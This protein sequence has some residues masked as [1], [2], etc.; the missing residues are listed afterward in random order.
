MKKLIDITKENTFRTI[1]ISGADIYYANIIKKKDVTVI[2]PSDCFHKLFS[3]LMPMNLDIIYLNQKKEFE[4]DELLDEFY[5][6]VFV[7]V[8]F[9]YPLYLNKQK[10]KV[11]MNKTALLKR[12]E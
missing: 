9:K 5:T 4:Y 2:N 1:N 3:N 12:N 11:L 10:N 7:N 6:Y 8:S